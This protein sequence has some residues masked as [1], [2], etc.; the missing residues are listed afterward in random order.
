MAADCCT[1]GDAGHSE[2]GTSLGVTDS[3]GGFF[4]FVTVTPREAAGCLQAV[5]SGWERC[6]HTHTHTHIRTNTPALVGVRKRAFS[7]E[8]LLANKKKKE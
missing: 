3:A 1:G 7:G 8:G 5:P 4:F 2:A 6:T